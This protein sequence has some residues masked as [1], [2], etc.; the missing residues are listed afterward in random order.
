MRGNAGLPL[1][2]S[3]FFEGEIF[4]SP[5][6]SGL[7]GLHPAVGVVHLLADDDVRVHLNIDHLAAV[8]ALG[9]KQ[10]HQVTALD[11]AFC[12]SFAFARTLAQQSP[13]SRA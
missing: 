2:R 9:T 4:G 6:L 3:Y 5:D 10:F 8:F 11:M 1:S 7:D 12:T 13:S